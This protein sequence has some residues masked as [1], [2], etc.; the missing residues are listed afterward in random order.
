MIWAAGNERP[1]LRLNHENKYGIDWPSS[2]FVTM[3][4]MSEAKKP[5]DLS[6]SITYEYI[7]KNSEMG[8][9]YKPATL[10]W[11]S[12]GSPK[13]PTGK[14]SYK[15]AP[16][17]ATQNA[18]LLYAI[19]HMHDGGTHQDLKINGEVVCD[20][21]MFYGRREGYGVAPSTS[22]RI[23]GRSAEPQ[24]SHEGQSAF[25]GAHISDPGACVN[26]GKIKAG[27]VMT[28]EAFYDMTIHPTMTHDGKAERI[29]GNMRVYMGPT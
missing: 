4:L 26:F 5:I 16:W 23:S 6:M 18:T 22:K 9:I 21:I 8:K 27:D 14:Q 13:P 29:M 28:S 24:H 10:H 25:G 17:R 15:S 1:T 12:I 2:L 11:N 7:E 3:D 20:S 19:G